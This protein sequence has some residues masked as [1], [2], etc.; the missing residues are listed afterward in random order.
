MDLRAHLQQVLS[1]QLEHPVYPPVDVDW[2]AHYDMTQCT[3]VIGS[4]R[5][6]VS[7]DGLLQMI[8][9]RRRVIEQEAEDPLRFGY[10]PE[11][12]RRVD[13]RVAQM[14]LRNPGVQ[15]ELLCMGGI[16]SGKTEF[17]TKR[18]VQHFFW[19]PGAWCWGLHE[20]ETS[21]KRIQ[22]RR[23]HRFLPR[24]LDT[25]T[26]KHKKDK[27]THFS[28]SEG[29]GFTGNQ[30]TLSW[31]A[32]DWQQ[33]EFTGGG[34]MDFK[35][36]KSQDSTLQ[37]AELTCA[38][39]DELI[40]KAT[41]DTVR[42]RLLSRS[43]DTKRADHV[44]AIREAIDMLEAGQGLTPA[45]IAKVYHGV[46]IIS[47]T[48]KEGYSATVAD[49]LDGAVTI[50]DVETDLIPPKNGVPARVP[51]FKQPKKPTRLVAY[52]HTYDNVFRGNWPAMVQQCQGAKE[53]YVRVIAFGDVGKGWASTFPKFRDVVHVTPRTAVPKEGTWY[54]ICDPAGARNWFLIWGMADVSG[55]LW[56]VREWPQEGDMIPDVGDPGP[57]AVSSDTGARNGDAGDAQ[58]S[59]GW[60]FERYASEIRRVRAEIGAWWSP[61]EDGCS[62]AP[63][64]PAESYMDSRLGQAQT[65]AHGASTTILECLNELPGMNWSPASGDRLSEGDALINDLLDYD[66]TRPVDPLNRPRLQVTENCRAVV[67][68]FQNY[69]P[70]TKP[71]DEA[72]KDPRD[73]VAYFVNAQPEYLG[74]HVME[75]TGGGCY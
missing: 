4:R 20:I 41:C 45:L 74:G 12:W 53:D 65:V 23:V 56:V 19:T 1:A 33:C 9:A 16:R 50:E 26:G 32:R 73:C 30:F 37:G 17:A 47:F 31:R 75:A 5:E 52:F 25:T 60:G 58:D 10:E 54:E 57:W 27:H 63:I 61:S 39:S 72:C 66:E 46:H 70:P 67:F 40:P 62:G 6:H 29:N 59:F 68:M 2:D 48:P 36:Y 21:S 35:F 22:Q 64:V 71:R 55:R 38:T 51:R 42:E 44:A 3:A 43:E 24:E 15:L 28:Y 18:M 14:R 7:M 34:M 49:Y 8:G 13:L 11:F 69:G